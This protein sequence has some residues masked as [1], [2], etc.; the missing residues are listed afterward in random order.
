MNNRLRVT[1]SPPRGWRRDFRLFWFAQGASVTGD[2]IREFAVPLIAVSVLHV[3]SIDLGV[4]GAAQWLPF[5]LLSLP[6]GVVIDRHRRRT[7]LIV[8]ELSRGILTIGLVVAAATGVLGFPMLLVA[9]IVLGTFTVVYEIGHQSAIP[10]LVPRE[11][12]GVANSRIQATAAAG[13]VGGPGLGGLLLQVFG[14]TA[15]LAVNAVTYVLSAVAL[16]AMRSSEVAPIADR[17]NFLSELRAGARHVMRDPFLRANVGFSAIYNPFAQWVTL[18]LTLYAVRELGLS[19][20]QV[21]IVFSAGAVGA[22]AGASLASR[23]SSR[24]GAV[25]VMCAT[26]E[27]AALLLIPV[28]DPAWE[29]FA[30]VAVL[31]VLMAVNGMGTALSSVLL[32]TIRQ[33]RTPNELLGRVNATMRCVTYGTIPLG[34]LAGGL[35]GDVLG[36]RLG[37]LVGAV[38]CLS[39]IAWVA[40][41][42]LRTVRRLDDIALDRAPTTGATD[43]SLSQTGAVYG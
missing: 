36:A 17:R 14:V 3:S 21:G 42:P 15:T 20:A 10:A 43:A 7:M 26:V 28:V 6:L 22:L 39:T 18:L 24:V 29:A 1:S 35:V 27:C 8:S 38:L 31:S 2:Q 41:S 4:L 5:L 16:I 37:I 25:M 23:L 9:V 19:A 34:A 11:R 30:S 32:I 12:L 33:L 13:E 40:L